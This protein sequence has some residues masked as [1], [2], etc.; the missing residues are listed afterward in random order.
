MAVNGLTN[1]V[2]AQSM[3][4][5]AAAGIRSEA[6]G[7]YQEENEKKSNSGFKT[8]LT[9]A[10]LGAITYG[11]IR[12]RN[13]KALKPVVENFEKTTKNG[14][15]LCTEYVKSKFKN[16]DGTISEVLTK[17]V[18]TH[19]DKDG[20]KIAEVIHN[21]SMGERYT[22]LYDKDGN[23]VKNVVSRMSIPV[24][25]EKA[26]LQQ[27]LTNAYE[28]YGDNVITKSRLVDYNGKRPVEIYANTRTEALKRAEAPKVAE[29]VSQEIS[30]AELNAKNYDLEY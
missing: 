12:Y 2:Q 21:V 6:A 24:G 23:V 17:S 3:G 15:K 18:K 9:L 27:N 13:A 11:V 19:Y 5:P 4:A 10:T 7:Y 20:K 16:P 1:P 30:T 28:R 25:A 14:G 26:V 22:V 29:V 8:L